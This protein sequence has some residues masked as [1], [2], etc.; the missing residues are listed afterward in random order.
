[1]CKKGGKQTEEA[2]AKIR[3]AMLMRAPCSEETRAKLRAASARRAP[4]SDESKAKMRAARIGYKDSAATRAKKSAVLL[5][6]KR[7]VGHKASDE[8]RAKMS[9]ARKGRKGREVSAETRAKISAANRGRKITEEH[10]AII[11]AASLGKKYCLGHKL[12]EEHKA[13]IS[14][15]LEG[16]KRCLGHKPSAETLAK[17]HAANLGKHY[18]LGRKHS[19][20]AKARISAANRGENSHSWKGGITPLVAKLRN[21]LEY[22]TWRQ[23]VFQRDN[24]TC[25][26]CGV[27]GTYLE[28]HHIQPFSSEHGLRFDIN[29]GVTLCRSCHDKTKRK[30]DEYIERFHAWISA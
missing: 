12:T 26:L 28:A 25:G 4:F 22:K 23:S 20:E 7:C 17:L 15:S 6:H 30:E 21:S 13:K 16:N 5:G 14:A 8:T 2:K 18:M 1:M 9:A 10:K 11:R 27:R 19:P 24:F 3:A 29:N